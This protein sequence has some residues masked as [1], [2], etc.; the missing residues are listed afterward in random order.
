MNVRY[1]L[2]YRPEHLEEI[3]RIIIWMCFL[4][5]SAPRLNGLHE[6][7]S[8]LNIRSY[9]KAR[10][11]DSDLILLLCPQALCCSIKHLWDSP[12]HKAAGSYTT[13]KVT[14]SL[15]YFACFH[16]Q[17]VFRRQG[18]DLDA[19][20]SKPS[21]MNNNTFSSILLKIGC[22]CKEMTRQRSNTAAG[23]FEGRRN[24][25]SRSRPCW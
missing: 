14:R 18:F 11:T 21:K 3:T 10:K 1:W 12:V 25:S 22:M 19:D 24:F 13:A 6:S 5:E 4:Q 2:I 15:A 17:T 23:R 16:L 20:V 7:N 9:P 8:K